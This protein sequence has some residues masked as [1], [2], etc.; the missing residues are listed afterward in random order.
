MMLKI[1]K[2][3]TPFQKMHNENIFFKKPRIY[4]SRRIFIVSSVKYKKQHVIQRKEP[5]KNG[6]CERI[7]KLTCED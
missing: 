3:N 7:N 6:Y 4:F 1:Q 5:N 2:V